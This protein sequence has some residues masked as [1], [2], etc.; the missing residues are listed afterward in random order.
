MKA[1]NFLVTAA[2]HEIDSY[3]IAGVYLNLVIAL[4]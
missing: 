2:R 1:I 3:A 4:K